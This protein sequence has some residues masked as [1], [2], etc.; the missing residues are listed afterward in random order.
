VTVP[1]Q[2]QLASTAKVGSGRTATAIGTL[3]ISYSYR[4]PTAIQGLQYF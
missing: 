4:N 1:A 3:K 2:L